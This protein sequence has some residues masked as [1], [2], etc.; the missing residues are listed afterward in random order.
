MAGICTCGNHKGP[1]SPPRLPSHLRHLGTQTQECEIHRGWALGHYRLLECHMSWARC[2]GPW[3]FMFR[4]PCYCIAGVSSAQLKRPEE[5]LQLEPI[6][7]NSP[8]RLRSCLGGS[9]AAAVAIALKDTALYRRGAVLSGKS[10]LV[11]KSDPTSFWPPGLL[12]STAVPS[13]HL[14]L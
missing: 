10:I 12:S 9:H 4:A 13:S 5:L 7:Q 6:L 2:Q 11:S 14:L 8:S 3:G 1:R